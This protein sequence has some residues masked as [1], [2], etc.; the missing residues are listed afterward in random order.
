VAAVTAQPVPSRTTL[1]ARVRHLSAGTGGEGLVLAIAVPPL[2]L[3][4]TYQPH[5]S[6][7]LA[8]TTVDVTLADVAI[9]AVAVAA[10]LRIRRDGLGPLARA[11][12]VLG[13]AA[14][15]VVLALLSLATPALRGED[16]AYAPHVVSALK[17]AWYAM[18]LPATVLA[19]RSAR[20]AVPLFRAVTLWGAAALGWGLLQFLGVVAE[21]Q[22]KRPGQREP[23]FLGTHDFAALSGA[24]LAVGLAALLLADGRP[25]AGG[26]G[27][28][29]TAIVAGAG[30]IVLSGALTG[31][32]GLWLA[33][34]ALLVAVRAVQ[35]LGAR[36]VAATLGI[37]FAVTVGAVAIRA[38]AI[39]AFAEFLGLRE[40]ETRNIESYAQRTLLAYIGARIWLDHPVVGVGFQASSEEWAYDPYLDDARRRFPGEPDEAFPS[41]ER[42]WG[43]QSLYVQVPADMGIVGFAALL[44]LFT[45]AVASAVRGIRGSPVPLVGLAWLLVATGVWAG[46][47][48]V[49]GIPLAALTFV[50]LALTTVRD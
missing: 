41:P 2:F 45:A 48:L 1:A 13:A 12:W 47:G 15:F 20:E 26:R 31:V 29:A 18:L 6:I 37:V 43:V 38:E 14:A 27:W 23:S 42:P 36:R 4:A 33:A 21:L 50:A 25:L 46:I 5:V 49:P 11:R 22:G 8:S 39:E 3:H 28:T 19:V 24:T 30:G 35:G 32:G 34:A 17:L 7:G 10:G 44:G 40:R 16:Y 9:A